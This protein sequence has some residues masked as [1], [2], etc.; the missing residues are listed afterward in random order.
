MSNL[1]NVRSDMD[2]I[3]TQDLEFSSSVTH[4]RVIK[5]FDDDNSINGTTDSENTI[6]ININPESDGTMKIDE[7]GQAIFGTAQ[8]FLKHQ[9]VINPT[10]TITPQ[11]DDLIKVNNTK[12]QIKELKPWIVNGG[13]AYFSGKLV[14]DD[15]N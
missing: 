2:T 12:Y 8:I 4:T 6:V 1:D 15:L 3:I 13:V 9:Y 5:T 7:L 10:T 14:R 11:N